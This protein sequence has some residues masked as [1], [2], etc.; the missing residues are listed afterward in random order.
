MTWRQKVKIKHLLTEDEDHES[1]QAS[2]NGIADI[3]DQAP[4]FWLFSTQ[5]FRKIP[6]GDDVFGPVDYGNKLLDTMY[7]YADQ[8]RIWIE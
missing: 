3:L 5:K 4:C 7:D 1:I 2:M 6:E 8:H